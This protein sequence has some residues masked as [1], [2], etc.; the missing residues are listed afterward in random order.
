MS[1]AE[2]REPVEAFAA[3]AADPALGVRSPKPPNPVD[4]TRISLAALNAAECRCSLGGLAE[5]G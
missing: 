4:A 2:D 5:D 3:H 1:A